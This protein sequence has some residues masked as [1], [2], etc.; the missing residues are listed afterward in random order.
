MI[1]LSKKLFPILEFDDTAEAIFSASDNTII[2]K[3]LPERCV[4]S[5]F[6]DSID[7]FVNKENLD[8]YEFLTFESRKIPL[9]IF[10]KN[11]T[12]I[13]VVHG[14]GSGPYAAGLLEKL[15]AFGCKKFIVCGGCGVLDEDISV[16]QLLLPMKALRDE[17]TSYHYLQPNQFINMDDAVINKIKLILNSKNVTFKEVVTWTTDAI[18][19]ETLPKIKLRREYGC[20]VVEMECASFLAVAKFRNVELGQILYS[21][22]DLSTNEW[23]ER[24]WK[25]QTKT[26]MD[27]FE[28][29][30]EICRCI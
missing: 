1:P 24:E 17:G 19:R 25:K 14:L 4:I 15:I 5:F 13:L 11:Q 10:E 9:Y 12:K 8:V 30:M 28:L 29:A 7:N 16:G 18:Y 27:I 2:S 20:N 3:P 26:R 21:G 22:D 6:G 23:S